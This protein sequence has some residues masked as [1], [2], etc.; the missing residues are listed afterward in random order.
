VIQA[1]ALAQCDKLDGIADAI[2]NDPRKVPFRSDGAAV[3]G[4]RRADCLTAPQ[5][6][7]VRKIYDGPRNPRTGQLIFPG[8]EAGAEAAAR[9]L[10]GMDHRAIPHRRLAH[11]IQSFFGNQFFTYIIFEDPSFDYRVF[12]FDFDVT[13][14]DVTTAGTI[15]RPIPT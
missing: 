1:A 2:I 10:V 11:H 13:F 8:Y 12:D 15:T 9:R 4:R 7:A 5:V 6:A 3:R 14:A